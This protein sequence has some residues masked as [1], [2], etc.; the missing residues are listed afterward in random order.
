MVVK[1]YKYLNENLIN[2]SL[3]IFIQLLVAFIYIYKLNLTSSIG[4]P[5]D[6]AYIHFVYA[7]N[8]ATYGELS[9]NPGEPSVGT[10]SILWVILLAIGYK[11]GNI[12]IFTIFL[13]IFFSLI[14]AFSI[15]E[16]TK[17][18]FNNNRYSLAAALLYIIPGNNIW[19]SLSGLEVTMFL[20]FGLL[21]ILFYYKDKL[22]LSSVFGGLLFLTRPEGILLLVL[23]FSYEVIFRSKNKR[24]LRRMLII[25]VIPAMI[26]LPY[27]IYN[28][29][30]TG[31]LLPTTFAGRRWLYGLSES[32]SFSYESS[33]GFI[34]SWG[35]R[36]V[37]WVFMHQSMRDYIPIQLSIII[38]AI[39]FILLFAGF[40]RYLSLMIKSYKKMLDIGSASIL[41]FL[42]FAI[43]NFVYSIILPSLGHA[44]RYQAINFIMI[45]I[46]IVLGIISIADFLKLKYKTVSNKPV[47]AAFFF[48][49]FIIN[50]FS[51]WSW[52]DIYVSSTTHIN[53]V[54]AQAGK[55]INLNLPKDAIV[56]S[57]DIGAVKYY[58]DRYIVDL[59][60]LIDEEYSKYL[61]SNRI[62]EYMKLKNTTY[63][64]M[65]EPYESNY[66]FGYS[67]GIYQHIGKE[68]ELK[69]LNTFIYPDISKYKKHGSA[70][71]N[72]HPKMVI[73]E[74]NWN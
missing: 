25:L 23:I 26:I 33:F 64:T 2:L 53:D 55:W 12:I 11:I 44:G 51:M 9:F 41:L 5:L 65:V 43:H 40:V 30:S 60:G 49:I 58:S 22:L 3:I 27:L 56:A 59:G 31:H 32:I 62:V 34:V 69:K 21:T 29:F 46:F 74:I 16:I 4:V 57:F 8:L 35:N 47:M 42:W 72:A 50:I 70:T 7:K 71:G 61:W 10:T 28:L 66:G 52:S 37:K 1:R 68:F 36:L 73:Y 67:L 24:S 45:W 14:S 39:L 38:V 20:A 54:H 13:G 63:L 17:S 48:F 6:D 19:L 18:L 15:Y